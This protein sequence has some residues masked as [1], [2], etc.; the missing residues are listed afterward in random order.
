MSAHTHACPSPVCDTWLSSSKAATALPRTRPAGRCCTSRSER[1]GW[2]RRGDS[3]GL[4]AP[5]PT[6]PVFWGSQHLPWM[7]GIAVRKGASPPPSAPLRRRAG[8]GTRPALANTPALLTCCC[9]QIK[10]LMSE[11]SH[12]NPQSNYR[13]KIRSQTGATLKVAPYLIILSQLFFPLITIYSHSGA[14]L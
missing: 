5:C 4:H 13:N 3:C 1:R 8:H 14:G 11:Q 9:L 12:L 7:D 2:R 6:Q 10:Q